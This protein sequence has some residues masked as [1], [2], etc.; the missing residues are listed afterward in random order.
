MIKKIVTHREPRHADDF[1]AVSLLKMSY[2][3]AIIE[4]VHPQLVPSEYFLDKEVC[5]V[6]VGG[7]YEPELFNFDHHQDLNIS[8]SLILVLKHM[9][10][11]SLIS[12]VLRFIDIADRYGVKKASE[13]VGVPLDSEEDRMRKEILLIDVGK[14]GSEVGVVLWDNLLIDDYS[15]WIRKVYTELEAR[16]LLDEPRRKL[17][18]EELKFLDKV[19]RAVFL[20][21]RGV[22]VCISDESFAP[23]H[24]RLFQEYGVDLL[25]ERNSMERGHTSVI[26]NTSSKK[27]YVIDVSNVFEVYP[28]VFLHKGGFIAVIGVPFEEVDKELVLELVVDK[29]V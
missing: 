8:C 20:D 22:K 19:N 6:D 17:Q 5:L 23:Y 13:D 16:G 9:Y 1:I 10:G 28:R 26:K 15:L 24:Y 4:T 21:Y 29:G 12:R 2:P 11:L 27:A 18:E 25:I 14:H 7:R 3:N